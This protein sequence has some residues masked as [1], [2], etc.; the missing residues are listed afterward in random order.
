[1]GMAQSK[2]IIAIN[3]DST[4]PIFSLGDINVVGDLHQIIP[5]VLKHLNQKRAESSHEEVKAL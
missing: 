2:D 4:A 1:M 5:E 3:I